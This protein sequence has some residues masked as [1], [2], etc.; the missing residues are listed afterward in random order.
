MK[1][2]V[3]EI[4]D[5]AE[6]YKYLKE[7][8]E[9]IENDANYIR[10]TSIEDIDFTEVED[11]IIIP[12]KVAALRAAKVKAAQEFDDK[13]AKLQALPHLPEEAS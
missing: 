2:A 4:L 5:N 13:I 12:Q 7:V 3:Y 6:R 1:I 11:A 9:Y 8:T 10:V